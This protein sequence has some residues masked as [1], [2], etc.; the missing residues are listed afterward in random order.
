MKS[1]FGIALLLAS[2]LVA[3]CD[4]KQPA[5]AT[6][7]APKDGAGNPITAPVDYLG[8]VVGQM[9]GMMQNDAERG[10]RGHLPELR[11]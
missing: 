1:H 2:M 10:S 11:Q 7:P 8:A 3:G 5:A 4:K 6:S 9:S